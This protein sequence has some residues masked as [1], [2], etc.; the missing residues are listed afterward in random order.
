MRDGAGNRYSSNSKADI[1]ESQDTA[2][3]ERTGKSKAA[4]EE[5]VYE[6]TYEQAD[7]AYIA[8][9]SETVYKVSES[10]QY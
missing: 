1:H 10:A 6:N 2:T 7:V 9:E 3:K 4:I 5:S 8:S